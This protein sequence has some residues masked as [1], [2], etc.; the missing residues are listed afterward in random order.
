M[1]DIE[2]EK[3]I[4]ELNKIC[5]QE[6]EIW[7][8]YFPVPFDERLQTVIWSIKHRL[9]SIIEGEKDDI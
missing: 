5:E 4:T 9:R 2:K 7:E 6:I 1:K 8:D 3:L